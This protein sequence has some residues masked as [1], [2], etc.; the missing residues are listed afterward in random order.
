MTLSTPA[1]LAM[2]F[3]EVVQLPDLRTI[4]RHSGKANGKA[5]HSKYLYD[6]I[7]E[8][9]QNLSQQDRDSCALIFDEINVLGDLAFKIVN[10]E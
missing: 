9:G 3:G 4:Q 7:R 1:Y 8:S 6:K 5:G 10:G 2:C